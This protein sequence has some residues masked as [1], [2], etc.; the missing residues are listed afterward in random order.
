MK[1]IFFSIL[2]LTTVVLVY[3]QTEILRQ[4]GMPGQGRPG[5]NQQPRKDSSGFEQRDD[6]KDSI[7]ISYR[8]M[9]ALRRYS[10][11]SSVN[12]N[13]KYFP[14]P[15]TFQYLGNNGAA[16]FPLVFAPNVKTGWDAGFHAYDVYRFTVEGTRFYKTTRPFSLLGYQLA[17]GKEQN[18]QAQHT[19]NIKPNFNAGFD[20]RLINAPGF[21]VNQNNNHNN[22]RFFANYQGKRKRYNSFFVLLN[23]TI[24]ADGQGRIPP[25]MPKATILFQVISSGGR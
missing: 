8:Y 18:V 21:F 9:D 1:K 17:S 19:Q 7:T 13:D 3:G 10:L 15:S 4:P 23:N 14:V 22:I 12:D 11:D 2:F 24:R 6:L 20:Y 5:Q 16:A 25:E